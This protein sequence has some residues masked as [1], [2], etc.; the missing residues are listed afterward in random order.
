MK[1][2]AELK[3]ELDA[4]PYE[5]LLRKWRTVP[6]GDPLF[7]GES[8]DYISERMSQLR[9]EGADHVASSKKIGWD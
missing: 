2:T 6:L 7:Q 1:L 8:G 4:L 3:A 9:S 5:G